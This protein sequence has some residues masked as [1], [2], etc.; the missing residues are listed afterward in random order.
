MP[1]K[2]SRP[3]GDQAPPPPPAGATEKWGPKRANQQQP[4]QPPLPPQ[5]A[6][7]NHYDPN[8]RSQQQQY[9][10]NNQQQFYN[11]DGGYYNNGNQRQYSQ[12]NYPNNNQQGQNYNNNYSNS[13][14]NQFNSSPN[15]VGTT[16]TYRHSPNPGE[17]PPAGT[18]HHHNPYM[19]STSSSQQ[20]QGDRFG[21]NQQFN[22][23]TGANHSQQH[24]TSQ[25]APPESGGDA[26]PEAPKKMQSLKQRNRLPEPKKKA[27][28]TPAAGPS[29]AAG[30]H[31]EV[32]PSTSAAG[33]LAQSTTSPTPAEPYG[34]PHAHRGY[35]DSHP[36]QQQQPSMMDMGHGNNN[37]N[38][39]NNQQQQGGYNNYGNNNYGGQNFNNNNN[40]NSAPPPPPQPMRGN[41]NQNNS[42]SAPPPPPQQHFNPPMPPANQ[43]QHYND[44]N[45]NGGYNDD[46]YQQCN[47]YQ[48]NNNQQ[49][50]QGQGQ[51]DNYDNNNYGNNNNN[52]QYGG[53]NGGYDGDY[54]QNQ[55]QGQGGYDGPDNGGYDNNGDGGYNDNV[56]GGGYHQNQG[57]DQ[58]QG[59]FNPNQ[60]NNNQRQNFNNNQG[61]NNYGSNNN[62]GGNNNNYG[63]NNQGNSGGRFNDNNGYQ[64]QGNNNGQGY[65]NNNQN[66]GSNS[67][68]G[69]YPPQNQQQQQQWGNNNNNRGHMGNQ[70]YNNNAN[71]N[72]NNDNGQY[73]N[74]G[75]PNHQQ[76]QQ[77]QQPAHSMPPQPQ[78]QYHGQQQ[79]P[80]RGPN[81]HQPPAPPA[82]LQQ[83]QQRGPNQQQ[84]RNVMPQ[85]PQPA[86]PMPQQRGGATVAA[87]HSQ[88]RGTPLAEEVQPPAPPQQ[89]GRAVRTSANASPNPPPGQ[90]SAVA[91]QNQQ[92]PAGAQVPTRVSKAQQ[93]L[94]QQQQQQQQQ[95]MQQQADPSPKH[96]TAA[97]QQ[98]AVAPSP[99]ANANVTPMPTPNAGATAPTNAEAPTYKYCA[100][101]VTHKS[102]YTMSLPM[103][104][105]AEEVLLTKE[106][107]DT[108]ENRDSANGL[109]A[110]HLATRD[111]MMSSPAAANNN[112]KAGKGGKGGAGASASSAAVT[113]L[114]PM[115]FEEFGN[116]YHFTNAVAPVVPA[117][118]AGC[119]HSACK[120]CQGTEAAEVTPLFEGTAGLPAAAAAVPTAKGGKKDA[121]DKDAPATAEVERGPLPR[122]YHHE[123]EFALKDVWEAFDRPYGVPVPIATDA[124]PFINARVS[125][126]HYS[127]VLAGLHLCFAKDSK[128]IRR[129]Q[130]RDRELRQRAARGGALG[131]S[132]TPLE[133]ES[134]DDEADDFYTIGAGAE[135]GHNDSDDDAMAS[136]FG[137]ASSFDTI[138]SA[139]TE[140]SV[141]ASGPSPLLSR[142]RQN[143]GIAVSAIIHEQRKKIGDLPE[144]AALK[145][146]EQRYKSSS[147]STATPQQ[148]SFAASGQL[149][150]S[151]AEVRDQYARRR[152]MIKTMK[153]NARRSAEHMLWYSDEQQPEGRLPLYEQIELLAKH[154]YPALMRARNTDFTF[155]SWIAVLW[156][157]INTSNL[158]PKQVGKF[159]AYYAI[160]PPRFL[161]EPKM[162]VGGPRLDMTITE[163][164]AGATAA[165]GT[166]TTTV[167]SP[168]PA[169][170]GCVSKNCSNLFCS[171]NANEMGTVFRTD[172]AAL[173]PSF[174]LWANDAHMSLQNLILEPCAA[175]GD[176]GKGGQPINAATPT[177]P[178]APKTYAA[179]AAAAAANSAANA[180]TLALPEFRPTKGHNKLTATVPIV[181]LVPL[182]AHQ[183]PRFDVWFRRHIRGV[184]TGDPNVNTF[185]APLHLLAVAASIMAAQ[186]SGRE[187]SVPILQHGDVTI[188]G[189]RLTERPS[190]SG[191]TSKE[192]KLFSLL[193]PCLTPMPALPQVVAGAAET[194]PVS[195][196][197]PSAPARRP[198]AVPSAAAANDAHAAS[199]AQRFEIINAS[200]VHMPALSAARC[201]LLER[202][203]RCGHRLTEYEA[204]ISRDPH[205]GHF[206]QEMRDL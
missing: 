69:P 143:H 171:Y 190:R 205:V 158:A 136:S 79:P 5:Q 180:N 203:V 90:V 193:N 64:Q 50:H 166:T 169:P 108:G 105:T 120:C 132:T 46:G 165:D 200:A 197:A 43:Q 174:G 129:Q 167:F 145:A 40:N 97:P 25:P 147:A 33:P 173:A 88:P 6:Q 152:Q 201:D 70:P 195:G 109:L 153:R 35:Y 191:P 179:V 62:Y 138:N 22:S 34:A 39:N 77:P 163:R 139:S 128:Y 196:S 204:C 102:L 183:G 104:C 155:N 63:G 189:I 130:L 202:S 133:A 150:K 27:A 124:I 48:G 73:Q 72:Y 188:S 83:Q 172:A 81:Q 29:G 98:Q 186:E 24:N 160:R 140:G 80:Q 111:A 11:N 127:P 15:A 75:G 168:I 177:S 68:N 55:G 82:A 12:N 100:P 137:S 107:N 7:N 178:T 159:L 45:N 110:H 154:R 23:S 184:P 49:Y 14:N 78:Q 134:S 106:N 53:N 151:T 157:P 198:S 135:D 148:K 19:H 114:A 116:I 85:Q 52:N 57:F 142:V 103:E 194:L 2:Q 61:N 4:P 185:T 117:I 101:V 38:Y 41:S 89:P 8:D 170:H 32:S 28:P 199:L 59:G 20:P 175:G 66:F 164:G 99:G 92:Q 60:R 30:G 118:H 95:Q 96:P 126:L 76:Y 26:R 84:P 9:N 16:P 149:E 36:T 10:N 112:P 86:Q 182:L 162:R 3:A 144:F 113:E 31:A 161:F 21:G 56:N 65:G 67:N 93:K 17:H 51:G 121:K 119:A 146:A 71:N 176:C 91:P 13:N 37:N 1:P 18:H 74:Y 44:Q 131:T 54:Q 94:L 47:D 123:C 42:G 122:T 125:T 187:S 87:P 115:S 141:A 206:L 156:Q 192:A 58:G 181:G